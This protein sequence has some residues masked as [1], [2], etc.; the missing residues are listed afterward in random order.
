MTKMK[1]AEDF[2]QRDFEMIELRVPSQVSDL[3]S[4]LATYYGQNRENMMLNMLMD[5]LDGEL[6]SNEE[7]GMMISKYL[8]SKY[9]FRE[10]GLNG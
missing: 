6:R 5:E 3:L 1:R 7:M 10:D 8:R 2:A 9:H 4:A